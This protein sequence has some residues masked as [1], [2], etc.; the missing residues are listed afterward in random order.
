M[1]KSDIVVFLSRQTIGGP[2]A[3]KSYCFLEGASP[4]GHPVGQT[5]GRTVGSDAWTVGRKL[6]LTIGRTYGWSNGRT[7]AQ[8][9][10]GTDEW[11][12]SETA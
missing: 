9:A 12:H 3:P 2:V 1:S 4:A 8:I 5:V 11:S 10:E 7:D 6:G